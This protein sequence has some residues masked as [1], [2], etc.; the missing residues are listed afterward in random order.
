VA[1]GVA[2]GDDE[3][4]CVDGVLG[5]EAALGEFELCLTTFALVFGFGLAEALDLGV[6]L[7]FSVGLVLGVAL[8]VRA[9]LVEGAAIGVDVPVS[10][11]APSVVAVPIGLGAGAAV[12][13]IA[14]RR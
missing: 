7:V 5:V 8:E 6:E 12:A 14:S 4:L 13:R 10:V 2:L 11:G 9:G 1:L 3:T